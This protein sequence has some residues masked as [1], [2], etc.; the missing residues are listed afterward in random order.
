MANVGEIKVGDIYICKVKRILQHGVIVEIGATGKEGFIHISE[1]S[2]RWV[3]NVKDLV[4]ENSLVVCKVTESTPQSVS[5]SIK[6][7][8]ENEKKQSLKE[9]S[10]TNRLK[11]LIEKYDRSPQSLISKIEDENGSLYNLYSELLEGNH[12]ALDKL[13]LKQDLRDAVMKFVEGTRKKLVLKSF[14]TIRS[15]GENGIDDIKKL[16]SEQYS[17]RKTWRFTYVKAPNY[18]LEVD[19]GSTK[20]TLAENKK[21]LDTLERGSQ[22]LGVE[23]E[24]REIKS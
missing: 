1:L 15:Y 22:E 7:V 6:R 23:F 5:L 8:G 10:V 20:R 9:W 12:D 2:N 18:L 21:I 16:L 4:R 17:S 11:K 13:K 14:L 3:K 24:H 19:A